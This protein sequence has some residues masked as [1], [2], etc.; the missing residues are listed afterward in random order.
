[1]NVW[2]G[3]INAVG[4]GMRGSINV[5]SCKNDGMSCAILIRHLS[6]IDSASMDIEDKRFTSIP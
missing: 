1:M 6:E 5:D 2:A 3:D 4:I